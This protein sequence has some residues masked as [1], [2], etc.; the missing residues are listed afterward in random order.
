[1]TVEPG[2]QLLHYRIVDKLGEGGMGAVWRATDTTLGRDVAVKI[3]PEGFSH[4]QERRARFEREAKVLASLDHDNI[5]TIHGLHVAD[6]VHFLVMELVTGE[7]LA[8]RLA[9]SR[10]EPKEA[11]GIAVQVAA[12]LEAAHDR[13]IVHRD[14]KPANIVVTP[15]GKAKVLDFGLARPMDAGGPGTSLLAN[16]PTLTSPMTMAGAI[17]GTAAYMSPEQARGKL[18]DRR[19][20]IWAFGCVLYEMLVG[21]PAFGGETVTDVLASVVKQ[22]PDWGALPAETP[23]LARSLLRRCLQKDPASRLH[24]IADARIEIEEA[25]DDLAGAQWTRAALVAAPTWKRVLPWTVAGAAIVALLVFVVMRAKSPTAGS[26]GIV[27]QFEVPL[28]SGERLTTGVSVP[29][30]SPAGDAVAFAVR[31]GTHSRILLR[32]VGER[33]ARPIRGTE[34]G[35]LPFFSPDGEWIGFTRLGGD[36]YKIPVA[37][38]E[39][40]VLAEGPWW[41]S[42][43]TWLPDGRIIA[44][45][46]S[47]DTRLVTVDVDTRKVTLLTEYHSEEKDPQLY[48]EALPD[49]TVLF[50]VQ[51]DGRSMLA[52][53][54]PDRKDW[55]TLGTEGNG[56]IEFLQAGYL[57]FQQAGAIVV[58]E[59]DPRGDG[60]IGPATRVLEAANPEHVAVSSSGTAA[61]VEFPEGTGV[62]LVRVDRSGR[63]TPLVARVDNYRWPRLSPDGRRLA[64]GVGDV[65][66][67][68]L[69]LVDLADGRR[70]L[71]QDSSKTMNTEPV[72]TPGGDRIAYG[73]S[74]STA[75]VYWLASRGGTSEVLSAEPYDQWP[76][77]FSPDGKLLL[78]YTWPSVGHSQYSDIRVART[79]GGGPS[80]VVVD[81]PGQ[82]R[83]GR[84]SPDGHWLVYSSE[85]SGESAIYVRRYPELDRKSRVSSAGGIDPSWSPDGRE[86][87]Y[88][89]GNRMISVA[90]DPRGESPV[91]KEAVL[92]NAP[93]VFDPTGDQSYDVFPDGQSF[94]MMFPDLKSPPRLFV[95]TGLLEQV[96]RLAGT[97]RSR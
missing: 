57:V 88:L 23:P 37:G 87:F 39:R 43:A 47:D 70:D 50:A 7:D 51:H 31:E 20:D 86:I 32:R 64:V 1:M 96:N 3:L 53:Y 68:R 79:D 14:V 78:F 54:F 38:G 67:S 83:G 85:E 19:A 24:D 72:W 81:D 55:T 11:L 13:G 52:R 27:T 42:H 41:G 94:V 92:F 59:F 4:D 35:Q 63:V 28:G 36:M 2:S 5:A 26:P 69:W 22:E 6:G 40:S 44:D 12:A 95:M 90:F 80:E 45:G 62:S 73:S 66:K 29:A 76:T 48:P 60:T 75:D 33:E 82:Q 74:R 25:A 77:S 16:S 56:P 30:V 65:R 84:F 8:H 15:D 49:G 17:L 10:I 71:V 21:A 18:V 93:F 91:G 97:A 9:R 34:D 58:A 46:H 89:D 61:Y